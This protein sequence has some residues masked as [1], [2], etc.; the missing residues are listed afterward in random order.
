MAY[1]AAL[2]SAAVTITATLSSVVHTP[3]APLFVAL[4]TGAIC[5]SGAVAALAGLAMAVE[6]ARL[7]E[8]AL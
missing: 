7:I 6:G 8:R 5:I 3:R 4:H 2:A 1:G